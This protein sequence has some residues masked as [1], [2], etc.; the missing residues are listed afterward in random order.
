VDQW[1]PVG[2][3]QLR[4]VNKQKGIDQRM[5]VEIRPG[6]RTALRRTFN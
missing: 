3:H 5:N 1:L 6:E 2:S 4:L